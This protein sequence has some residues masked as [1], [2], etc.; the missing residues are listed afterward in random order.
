MNEMITISDVLEVLAETKISPQQLKNEKNIEKILVQRL[1]TEFSKY[2][3]TQ[4]YSIGGYWG[5]KADIDINNGF[6]GIELKLASVLDNSAS[7]VQ[8]LFGQVVY[9][10]NRQYKNNLIV[11]IVGDAKTKEAAF[12]KEI[13]SFLK[14]LNVTP[15]YLSTLKKV[16]E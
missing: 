14:Q 1:Q 4:Q 11:V 6:I 16:K 3:V 13:F 2:P 7:N 8:R 9:Y 5:M 15:F 12:M 10:S